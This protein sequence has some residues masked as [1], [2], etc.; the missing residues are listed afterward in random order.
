M[1]VQLGDDGSASIR[2]DQ[3]RR[4]VRSDVAGQVVGRDALGATLA[5]LVDD[6]GC[7]I[8]VD[9]YDADGARHTD[10]LTPPPP[11]ATGLEPTQPSPRPGR[12]AR[13][14]P[15][16]AQGGFL[17]REAVLVAAVTRAVTADPDGQVTVELDRRLA[18]QAT[19][20]VLVFG[21]I[22]GSLVLIE[23]P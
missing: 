13:R 22:S 17:P 14:G 18:R 6:A 5:S 3:L 12:S 8:R 11:P 2:G 1:I 9:L 19:R 10:I 4:G 20:G 7:P 16:V 15:L 21:T 23:S